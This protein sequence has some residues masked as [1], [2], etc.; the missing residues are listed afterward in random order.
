MPEVM[1]ATP[2]ASVNSSSSPEGGRWLWQGRWTDQFPHRH[3]FPSD[4]SSP[5]LPSSQERQHQC[6]THTIPS[7][8]RSAFS[9]Q[10]QLTQNPALLCSH[11]AQST[12][13]T[14]GLSIRIKQGSMERGVLIAIWTLFLILR[15]QTNLASD[16]S[17]RKHKLSK[18]KSMGCLVSH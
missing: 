17:L 5:R 3:H 11:V 12:C 4:S 9:R 10:L 15:K 13:G 8:R 6:Q 2:K 14:E 1:S 16:I 7:R 18:L